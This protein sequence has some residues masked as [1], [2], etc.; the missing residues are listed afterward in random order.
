MEL[1]QT[2]TITVLK[3]IL[4]IRGKYLLVINV[5]RCDT[6]GSAN[7]CIEGIPKRRQFTNE[8]C[9]K[10]DKKHTIQMRTHW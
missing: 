1:L 8:S 6:L 3:I 2:V 10:K 4:I 9:K 5:F 7:V